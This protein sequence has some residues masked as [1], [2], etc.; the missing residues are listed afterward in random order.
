MYKIRWM[1]RP[2]MPRVLEIENQVF[3][4]P[5]GEDQFVTCLRRHTI[6]M[7]ITLSHLDVPIGYILY[8][9]L[10]QRVE[11]LNLAIDTHF[12]RG[13]VGTVLAQKMLGKIEHYRGRQTCHAVV[14]ETNLSMQLFLKSLDFQARH[15]YRGY[16]AETSE[17]AYEFVFR[18]GDPPPVVGNRIDFH[19]KGAKDAG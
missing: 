1:I 3:A 7:V 4:H 13:G 12:Q 16:Y 8:E 9:L 2:D 11:L 14:R 19:F 15:I 5:W 17:D 6:G 18:R 10:S